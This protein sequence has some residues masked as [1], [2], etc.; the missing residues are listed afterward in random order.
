MQYFCHETLDPCARDTAE[1]CKP[2]MLRGVAFRERFG[3]CVSGQGQGP[4]LLDQWDGLT[5]VTGGLFFYTGL[6]LLGKKY[7]N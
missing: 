3:P 7:N 4:S 1:L 6:Y 5:S 2:K